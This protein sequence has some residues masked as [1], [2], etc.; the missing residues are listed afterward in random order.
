MKEVSM[1]TEWRT[2]QFFISAKGVFEVSVDTE[3]P[4]NIRCTCSS[5]SKRC[6][7]AQYVYDVIKNNGGVWDIEIPE[8]MD[9]D[10]AEEVITNLEAFRNMILKYGEVVALD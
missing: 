4:Y 6:K 2:L 5:R 7:H 1:E 3:D 8:E 9:D 10:E